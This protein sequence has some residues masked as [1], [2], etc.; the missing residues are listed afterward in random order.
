M[1]VFIDN[2]SYNIDPHMMTK[3]RKALLS[4]DNSKLS[5]A[6]N[7]IKDSHKL[8]LEADLVINTYNKTL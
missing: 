2:E 7:I 5:E 8:I 6:I 4:N 1:I 3:L